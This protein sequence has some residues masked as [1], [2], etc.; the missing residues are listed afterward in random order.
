MSERDI[1][2]HELF[3]TSDVKFEFKH[4]KNSCQILIV[5]KSETPFNL[6]KLYLSL[7]E[8]VEQ[9]EMEIGVMEG[10]PEVQ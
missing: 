7:K 2:D 4:S 10:P 1:P 8:Y 3:D 5:V 9:I 6:M